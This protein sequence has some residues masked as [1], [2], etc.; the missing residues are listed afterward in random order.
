MRIVFE[1]Y[2]IY[3]AFICTLLTTVLALGFS[4]DKIE[5][6][7]RKVINVSF[8]LYGPVLSTICVYGVTDIKSLARICTL[9]GVTDSHTN[10]VTVFVLLGCFTFA[11]FVSFTMAME[12]TLD[13]A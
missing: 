1:C 12:Q 9:R 5:W 4:D 2:A 8:L 6:V 13:M 7:A 11:V 10:W 3:S